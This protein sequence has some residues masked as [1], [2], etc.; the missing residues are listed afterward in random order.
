VEISLKA[1]GTPKYTGNIQRNI[2]R[3]KTKKTQPKPAANPQKN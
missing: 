3:E 1:E 2:K